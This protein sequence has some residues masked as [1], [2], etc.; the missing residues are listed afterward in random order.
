MLYPLSYVRGSD[1]DLVGSVIFLVGIAA[2]AVSGTLRLHLWFTLR[3]YPAEW[4]AQ[5]LF[6]SRWTRL[7]DST[8]VAVL[9]AAAL[10]LVTSHGRMAMLLVTSAVAVLVAFAVIE[11]VTTRAAARDVS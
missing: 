1:R 6:T 5:R 2:A 4:T 9:V 10:L 7:S 3:A 8:F 11:P